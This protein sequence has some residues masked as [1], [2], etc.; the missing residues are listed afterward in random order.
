MFTSGDY[1]KEKLVEGASVGDKR[2]EKEVCGE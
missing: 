1:V 2:T